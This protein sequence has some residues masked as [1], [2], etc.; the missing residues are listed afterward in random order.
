MRDR[1]ELEEASTGARRGPSYSGE[2]CVEVANRFVAS[3][4]HMN[5]RWQQARILDDAG[6]IEKYRSGRFSIAL[7][8]DSTRSEHY[9]VENAPRAEGAGEVCKSILVAIDSVDS[10]YR[11][12]GEGRQQEPVFVTLAE[13]VEYPDRVTTAFVRLYIVE[14]EL[15]NSSYGDLYRSIS[16]LPSGLSSN[17]LRLG[18]EGVLEF[19]PRLTHW[20]AQSSVLPPEYFVDGVIKGR[21]QIV[22]GVSKKQRKISP[23]R[24]NGDD[25]ECLSAIRLILHNEF[26]EIAFGKGIPSGMELS[27][28]LIGPFKL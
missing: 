6:L 16:A 21:P 10:S 15:C 4:L 27:N 14:K 2:E 1:L 19:F 25:L 28:V 5:E 11:M 20:E 26:A 18:S 17:D 12:D 22:N 23:Q 9:H 13:L 7:Y 8:F 24:F 3:L